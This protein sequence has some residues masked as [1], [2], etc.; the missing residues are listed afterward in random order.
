MPARSRRRAGASISSGRVALGALRGAGGTRCLEGA[1]GRPTDAVLALMSA[2]DVMDAVL[3]KRPTL[4][5]AAGA[6]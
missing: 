2:N 6:W 5:L 4:T 3:D 1:D